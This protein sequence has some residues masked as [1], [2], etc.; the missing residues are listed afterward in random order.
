MRRAAPGSVTLR[1]ADDADPQRVDASSSA[2][3]VTVVLPDHPGAAYRV[4]AD[5]S[6]GSTQV[7]VRTDPSATRTIRAHSSA[8]SITVSYQ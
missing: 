6:A 4:D 2:G 3:S 5:S 7:G 1:W 8:G